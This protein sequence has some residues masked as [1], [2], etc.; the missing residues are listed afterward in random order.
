M[1]VGKL[2][3]TGSFFLV[4]AW[5]NY[6]DGQGIVPWAMLACVLHEVGHYSAIRFLGGD[7][8]LIRLTAV[9]GEMG[10][11]RPLGYCQEGIAALAGPGVNLLLAAFLSQLGW[12][13]TF[14]GINLMLGCFNLMPISRLDGGRALFCTLALLLG[15]SWA[16][17]ILKWLSAAATA[18]ILVLGMLVIGLGGNLTLLL[19]AVW[20]VAVFFSGK[21]KGNRACHMSWKRLK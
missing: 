10:L 6:V 2:E 9:G 20:L 8:R 4:W 11:A 1:K 12:G 16:E 13:Y 17:L 3:A 21:K 14:A 15:P 7:I 5:L 19:V 18:L